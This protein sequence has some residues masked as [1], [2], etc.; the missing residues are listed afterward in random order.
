MQ[1]IIVFEKWIDKDLIQKYLKWRILKYY[2]HVNFNNIYVTKDDGEVKCDINITMPWIIRSSWTFKLNEYGFP[3]TDNLDENLYD[4]CLDKM[5]E[6]FNIEEAQTHV[7]PKENKNL[8]EIKMWKNLKKFL[9]EFFW[10]EEILV[11]KY[12]WIRFMGTKANY[13]IDF[14][15]HIF[16]SDETLKNYI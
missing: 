1:H 11:S 16:P 15:D 8:S 5:P 7:T 9:S 6:E 14:T 12:E 2:Q 10:W 3:I 4:F 13:Y